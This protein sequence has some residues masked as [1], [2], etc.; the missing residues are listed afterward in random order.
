MFGRCFDC[1]GWV[2]LDALVVCFWFGFLL[3]DGGGLVCGCLCG[4]NFGLRVVVGVGFC[5]LGVGVVRCWFGVGVVFGWVVWG[6]WGCCGW[7]CGCYDFEERD[8][9]MTLLRLLGWVCGCWWLFGF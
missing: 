2:W 3:F 1:L 7:F 8:K 9:L 6:E 5:C 4:L